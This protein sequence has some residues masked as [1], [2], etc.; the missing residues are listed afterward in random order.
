M[1]SIPGYLIEEQLYSGSRTIVYRAIR[2][3][4]QKPVVIKLLKNPYP[5]FNELLQFRNQYTIAKSLDISGII[6]AYSLD[7]YGN[8]YALVMEDIQ[9]ISL[10]EY[11][12]VLNPISLQEILAIA[13]QITN[14][15]HNLHQSRIIH[16]DIKPDNILINPETKQIKLIDFSIASL[17]T[18]ETQ[19]IQ[20]LS[21]LEG[22]LSYISPEQT[23]R[24]N[25]G[26]DYRT[27]FYSLGITFYELLSG[28][29]PFQSDDAM[30]LVH[31]HIAKIPASIHKKGIPLV[32]SNIVTKLMAKNAEDRY[33]SALGL[34]H[35]LENCLIQLRDIGKIE[36]FAIGK[37]DICDRF[38]IPEKLYGRE[39]EVEEL[40]A[41]FERVSQ[42]NSELILVAGFSGVGKTAVVNEVHRPI[43]KQR[44]YFIKGKFDQFNRNIPFS[45]LVQALRDLMGQLRAESHIQLQQWKSKIL[46]AL[47]ENG[48]VIINVIPEL[49]Q[50]IGKQPPIPELSSSAAQ[51]RFNL[52]FRNFIQVFTTKEHPLVIFLDDLQWSDS[53]SLNLVKLLMNEGENLYLLVIG[54]YRDNEVFLA[55]PLMLTL[56]EI[57]KQQTKQKT[58]VNTITLAPLSEYHINHLVADTLSCDRQVAQPFTE[59][60]YQK[61]KG[62]PFFTTQFLIALY[63]EGLISFDKNLGSWECDLAQVKQLALTDDVVEFMA[64][65]LQKLPLATQKVLR[66]A[67]CIGNQFDLDTLTTVSEQSENDT[68]NALWEALQSGLLLPQTQVY[69]FFQSIPDAQFSIPDAQ[70]PSYKFLHD[71]VQQ[72]AYSLI[73]EDKKQETHLKI[74]HLLLNSKNEQEREEKIFTI[75]NQINIGADLIDQPAQRRELCKLNLSAGTK[76]KNATAY[77]AAQGYLQMGISLLIAN[78]WQSQYELTLALHNTAAEVAYLNSNYLTMEE[79]IDVVIKGADNLLDRIKVYEVKIQANIAQNQ[80]KQAVDIGLGI[81]NLLGIHLPENPNPETIGQGFVATAANLEGQTPDR[82]IELPEMKDPDKLAAMQILSGIWGAA[83]SIMPNLMPLIVL[84]MV[85]LSVKNGNAPISAFAYVLYGVLLCAAED[86]ELGYQFGQLSLDILSSF[87]TQAFKAKILFLI[88]THISIWREPIRT[89]LPTLQ[90]AYQVGL[91]TGDLEFSA[92]PSAI[93]AYYS[94]LTGN[95]LSEVEQDFVNYTQAITQIKQEYYL[96]FLCIWHQAVANLLGKN[97]EP[98]NLVGDICNAEELLSQFEHENVTTPMA[99]IYVNNLM[100]NCLFGNFPEAAKYVSLATEYARMVPATLLIPIS[101]FYG[102]LARLS[103]FTSASSAEQEEILTQVEES[104]EQLHKW[105]KYAPMNYL[106]HYHLIKAEQ[107]RVLDKK[108]EAIELYDRA[109]AGAKENEYLHE[110]GLANELAAKFCLNWGKE[111]FAASYMQEAYYCYARWGS[112][113]KTKDLEKRYPKLLTPILEQESVNLFSTIKSAF[114]QNVT[115]KTSNSS[116]SALDL[117]TV[118]KSSQAISEEIYLDQLLSTLMSVVIENAGADK[119]IFLSPTA[120][121]FIIEAIAVAEIPRNNTK[122]SNI[123]IIPSTLTQEVQQ[124]P[125]SIVRYVYRICQTLAINNLNTDTRFANDDYFQTNQPQSI[126]CAPIIHQGKLTGILYLENNLTKEAFSTEGIEL[127]NLICS[128]T[129]ISLE[130]ARLYKNLEQKVQERTEEL[131]NTLEKLKTTQKQ[132][133]ESEKMAALGGLVAGVAHEINTPVGTSITVVSTL[134]DET[135]RFSQT[136][137]QG[138]LK[139]S[140]LN[141]YLETAGESA[142][143]MLSNLHRA[144][145]LIQSFKQIAVD[146]SHLEQRHF[147]LKEYLEE[148]ALSLAPK[149]KQTHHTLIVSGDETITINSYPGALAQIVTNLVTNSLDHAYQPAQSGL[150]RLDISQKADKIKVQYSDNGCGISKENLG[151]IFEPFFTTARNQGG[152]GLGLHIV[153]NLVTQK[154]QGTIDVSSKMGMGTI[155][156]MTLPHSSGE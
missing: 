29:L 44:G 112:P 45:A 13:V 10:R 46:D 23:G 99:Y 53:E 142:Q 89:A 25:R 110:L 78:C 125:W 117:A 111:K 57:A 109:I 101:C 35:D 40:L 67:A 21:V 4:D 7:S 66:L 59:L 80:L 136:V 124:L 140:V 64:L 1:F 98:C 87:N 30:E 102:A 95:N 58:T 121:D 26:I 134:V 105:A 145:E 143:L 85:N 118:I 48:Q 71:R 144:G 151:K 22:T 149:L 154:L 68:A 50:I 75:V 108:L 138:Q 27:D 18:R 106:H 152:T 34:K 84:E 8:G 150:L 139:R 31:S 39:T 72:A 81:L 12:Q 47:G 20:S 41:A 97:E 28:E 11:T 70:S 122:V 104:L 42:G 128:Q 55:H 77:T 131:S 88:G 119:G 107:Q 153:Y 19:I 9:G 69:K 120:E 155:F 127:L 5:D 54:A 79:Y 146:Q 6:R 147:N 114:A 135:E 43:V 132:L 92:L 38:I 113:A 63:R 73:T 130:N 51:N 17:L 14:I 126:L 16:K 2:A 49:E 56:N 36:N 141:N 60:V 82:L 37:L 137:N 91:E 100:L 103:L 156:V 94:Y 115:F 61:T 33:Q 24:M 133:V 15:I 86:F 52:L 76:A 123:S 96:N 116:A 83:F 62:N 129:A 32:L 90:N 74:G 3:K 148:I 93:Y 65:Q